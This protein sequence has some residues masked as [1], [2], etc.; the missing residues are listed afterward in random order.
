MKIL[1]KLIYIFLFIV[2]G[3]ICFLSCS[4]KKNEEMVVSLLETALQQAGENRS[5][6]EKVLSHYQLHPADSLK[7]RAACFLIE[8]MSY[9]IYYRGER[10]EQYLTYYSLLR[11]TRDA[12]ITPQAVVDSIYAMYGTFHL[13]SLLSYKDIETVDS[14]Y[15]CKNI[16]WAFKVWKEQPWGKNISFADFC[17]YVLP[18]R[19]ADETLCD[20]REDMYQEYNS[21]LDSFRISNV[22][23]KEDP[24]VAARC[25]LDSLRKR[26][27]FFT[28]TGPSGLPHVGPEVAQNRTGSCRELSDYVVYVCRALGIPCAIDFMPIHGDGNDG[29]QWVSFTGK[30]D[31]LYYQEFLDA[32][33]EVR[34]NR[35]YDSS[36]I[37]V[38]R[39]TFSLNCVMEEEMQKLDS[40]VVPFFES[41][42]VIDVT[43]LYAKSY[44]KELKIPT[45]SIY[46]GKPHSRIAYLCA[47]SRMNW[48]PVAWAEFDGQNLVF[49]DIQKG[50]VMRV[51]TYEQGHLRFWTD[52][53][54]VT[55]SNEFHFFTPLDSVQDVALF[56]K[57]SLQS[58][59]KFQ[60]RMLGGTFEVSNDPAFQ[61]KEIIHMIGRKPERLQTVV[62]LNSAKPY[63]YIRYVGPKDAHC[64][65]AEITFYA[66]DDAIPLKGRA[67]GT[68]G[69]YQKDDSHEYPNVFDGNIETSFD[70]L[71]ATGGWAG[72]D[73]GSPKRIEKI[74]YTPRSYDNYI[75]P[76]DEYELFCCI[77][78]DKWDSFGVQISEADTL[79]YKDVPVNALLLLKNYSRGTQERI[80]AYE[81]GKQVWK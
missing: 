51:A 16:D 58:E 77:G 19:I 61:Q 44:K 9:Y 17:E 78:R 48:E 13:D 73:L 37:K 65:V 12:N 31:D 35:I 18:Y 25:L 15:L 26:K 76:G 23:D 80:F 56:S 14:A 40:V 68:P 3:N 62:Y 69:C 60:N 45:K 34:K 1:I 50:P 6:L 29:H 71:A 64:N 39:N 66:V 5:E 74:V 32:L 72:L 47:S 46:R 41:P 81:D 8:N 79:V 7:Y 27:K 63:R 52:A 21:L 2:F 59:E 70:C 43:D 75:R 10:L 30:Y 33:K 57:Y 20:W 28:T 36:K 38:Y 42:H 22:L 67:M 24:A 11:E 4:E 49:A 54:E 53:F 55:I